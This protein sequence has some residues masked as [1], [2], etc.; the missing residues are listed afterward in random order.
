MLDAKTPAPL[1]PVLVVSTS[2]L[3]RD[4]LVEV[5]VVGFA[6]NTIPPGAFL[7]SQCTAV[8]TT[9]ADSAAVNCTAAV[10]AEVS[11]N[12]KKIGASLTAQVDAWPIW[13]TLPLPTS[14]STA[15]GEEGSGLI[16][17]T[18]EI[19]PLH[20]KAQVMNTSLSR[21]LCMGFIT[22][23]VHREMGSSSSQQ[24]TE[25]QVLH[26]HLSNEA[27]EQLLVNVDDAA[28]LLVQEVHTLLRRA[29]LHPVYLRTLKV[30]YAQGSVVTEDLSAALN[31][32]LGA[33]LGLKK[34]SV[35]LVPMLALEMMSTRG[36]KVVLAAQ[37]LAFDLAQ[38]DTEEWV[39][40]KE[41]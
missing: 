2:G 36:C 8:P 25:L 19:K 7:S 24:G 23:S 38:L 4:A 14:T 13:S 29:H 26:R 3:P 11:D 17:T 39:H 18:E 32:Q 30:Y 40:V 16:S 37:V 20:Y 6:N 15:V 41:R 10:S 21:N 28:D 1:C 12:V 5:E 34:L 27:A 22:I 9:C 31:A 35:L 33:T